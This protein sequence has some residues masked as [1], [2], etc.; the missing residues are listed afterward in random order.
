V[1]YGVTGTGHW[2]GSSSGIP[3]W[4]E[5]PVQPPAPPKPKRTTNKFGGPKGTKKDAQGRSP[6]QRR[7]AG[8]NTDSESVESKNSAVAAN[9]QR[10]IDKRA[11][12]AAIAQKRAKVEAKQARR[13]A[14]IEKK[15][16]KAEADAQALIDANNQKIAALNQQRVA[17]AKSGNVTA[18]RGIGKTIDSLL[19]QNAGYVAQGAD[20]KVGLARTLANNT[21]QKDTAADG[22]PLTPEQKRRRKRRTRNAKDDII[23]QST[24]PSLAAVVHGEKRPGDFG[25]AKNIDR[26]RADLEAYYAAH[27]EQYDTKILNKLSGYLAKHQK[28]VNDE[29]EEAVAEG[30]R[31]MAALKKSKPGSPAYNKVVNKIIKLKAKFDESNVAQQLDYLYGKDASSNIKGTKRK[32]PGG[33]IGRYVKS[34]DAMYDSAQQSQNN[35][36]FGP[37]LGGIIRGA[38]AKGRAAV[39]ISDAEKTAHM[40][41]DP[42]FPGGK[43]MQTT[44]ERLIEMYAERGDALTEEQALAQGQAELIDYRNRG[45][46][47]MNDPVM[48][49]IVPLLVENDINTNL[50]LTGDFDEVVL[51]K[52]IIAPGVSAAQDEFKADPSNYEPAGVALG[53]YNYDQYGRDSEGEYFIL[54]DGTIVRPGDRMPEGHE[55]PRWKHGPDQSKALW[56]R[57]DFF[58]LAHSD[59]LFAVPLSVQQEKDAALKLKKGLQD[60]EDQV[61]AEF[62]VQDPGFIGDLQSAHVVG[63][64][65]DFFGGIGGFWLGAADLLAPGDIGVGFSND[66]IQGE[67]V[68]SILTEKMWDPEAGEAGEEVL[69]FGPNQGWKQVEEMP[70]GVG[71]THNVL[72]FLFDTQTT[73]VGRTAADGSQEGVI[74][75]VYNV[76]FGNIEITS[77]Q[78]VEAI[79]REEE[80][81]EANLEGLKS[82]DFGLYGRLAGTN[83]AVQLGGAAGGINFAIEILTDPTNVFPFA[84]V[85]KGGLRAVK[86]GVKAGRNIDGSLA[87]LANVVDAMRG[88]GRIDPATVELANIRK[89]LDDVAPNASPDEATEAFVRAIHN[90]NQNLKGD[91]AINDLGKQLDHALG[92]SA[93]GYDAGQIR[94]FAAEQFEA[95]IKNRGWIIHS[96]ADA[97]ALQL[98]AAAA[99]VAFAAAN[100]A[101][102]IQRIGIRNQKIIDDLSRIGE[103]ARRKVSPVRAGQEAF[104]REALKLADEI[105]LNKLEAMA[106]ED[107]LSKSRKALLERARDLSRERAGIK[108][109]A[110]TKEGAKGRVILDESAFK[111]AK[112]VSKAEA[113]RV[114]KAEV[115]ALAVRNQKARAAR[116]AKRRAAEADAARVRKSQAPAEGIRAPRVKSAQQSLPAGYIDQANPAWAQKSGGPRFWDESLAAGRAGG[117][118]IEQN[119]SEALNFVESVVERF[120]KWT[121]SVPARK[122][123]TNR[124]VARVF[125]D[126]K[127]LNGSEGRAL[128]AAYIRNAPGF[129][130]N[131][132]L[133]RAGDTITDLDTG[134]IIKLADTDAPSFDDFTRMWAERGRKGAAS[135]YGPEIAGAYEDALALG[136]IGAESA[137][138]RTVQFTL[139]MQFNPNAGADEALRYLDDMA[140]FGEDA[141]VF[142]RGFFADEINAFHAQVGEAVTRLG[143]GAEDLFDASIG[144]LALRI[145]GPPQ[146]LAGRVVDVGPAVRKADDLLGAREVNVEAMVN[147]VITNPED[148]AN[149]QAL[150]HL[151]VIANLTGDQWDAAAKAARAFGKASHSSKTGKAARALREQMSKEMEAVGYKAGPRQKAPAVSLHGPEIVDDVV[152]Q[153]FILY[154]G[155][156]KGLQGA[157]DAKET[158]LGRGIYL[159]DETSAAGYAKR[160]ARPLAQGGDEG[161]VRQ[162]VAPAGRY[163]DSRT[164]PLPQPILDEWVTYLRTVMA[165]E[166][167]GWAVQARA[168]STLENFAEASKK[169]LSRDLV[170]GFDADFTKMLQKR[171]YVGLLAK[172]GGEGA[173]VGTH[174]SALVF[175]SKSV[176]QTES[177]FIPDAQRIASQQ[178]AAFLN[179]M[180]QSETQWLQA[181]LR[182]NT[183]RINNSKTVKQER[184]WLLQ[185]NDELR[186]AIDDIKIRK[187]GGTYKPPRATQEQAMNGAEN[188]REKVKGVIPPK[189]HAFF[190][191]TLEQAKVELAR[192]IR[193]SVKNSTVRGARNAELDEFM[194]WFPIAKYA[195]LND[196]VGRAIQKVQGKRESSLNLRRPPGDE[197]PDEIL[198]TLSDEH[199]LILKAKV[200]EL[201]AFAR[202]NNLQ[203]IPVEMYDRLRTLIQPQQSRYNRTQVL[204][205]AADGQSDEAYL[206]MRRV[207]TDQDAVD[208]IAWMLRE[209]PGMTVDEAQEILAASY[210]TSGRVKPVPKVITPSDADVLGKYFEHLTGSNIDDI[211]GVK[212]ALSAHGTKPNF[213]KKYRFSQHQERTGE[214]SPRAAA[215]VD[216]TRP[217]WSLDEEK[218]WFMDRYGEAPAWVTDEAITS[219]RAFKTRQSYNETM[220]RVGSYDER[221]R[222]LKSL[223]EDDPKSLEDI[224]HGNIQKGI[225]P[226]KDKARERLWNVQ[227][228]G[229]RVGRV[230][231]D[232]TVHMT[233]MPWLMNS[234]ELAELGMS[235]V[236]DAGA[237][238]FK[239][240]DVAA[241]KKAIADIVE[242]HADD[243]E[244]ALSVPDDSY[245]LVPSSAVHEYSYRMMLE[246]G[247]SQPWR[248]AYQWMDN[249]HFL[250]AWSAV[251]TGLITGNPAWMVSNFVD[252]PTKALYFAFTNPFS[253]QASKSSHEAIRSLDDLGISS[254]AYFDEIAERGIRTRLNPTTSYGKAD[255]LRGLWDLATL[256]PV[257]M[258]AVSE[259]E[260]WAKTKLARRIYTG[261]EEE[262]TP[263][264]RAMGLSD[265]NVKLALLK[266][267]KDNINRMFPIL[268]N[269]GFAQKLLNKILPFISYNA[270]NKILWITEVMDHPWMI[271]VLDQ[272]KGGL[273]EYNERNWRED[274]PGE[275]FMPEHLFNQIR[276]PGTDIHIDL[277][278]FTDFARGRFPLWEAQT[279]G[280]ILNNGVRP[281]PSQ[282]AF[283]E[284]AGWNLFGA[285]GRQRWE[286][287]LNEDGTWSGEVKR[288]TVPPGTPWGDSAFDLWKD[289]AWPASFIEAVN[290]AAQNDERGLADVVR[291]IGSLAS[292][293]EFA[294]P[295]RYFYANQQY[296]LL[297]D[298]DPELARDWL[299]D[300]EEGKFLKS[301]WDAQFTK[302]THTA[303]DPAI[304][305][306]LNLEGPMPN[307]MDPKVIRKG[308]YMDQSP[309]YRAMLGD[310]WNELS[311]AKEY[312]DE[313]YDLAKTDAER[314]RLQLLRR[315]WYSDFYHRN[316]HLWQY[317][318]MG[319]TE[320][321]YM[322]EV[323]KNQMED[324]VTRFYSVFDWDLKP[325]GEKAGAIWEKNRE[326]Y[327]KKNPALLKYFEEAKSQYDQN[328]DDVNAAWDQAFDNLEDMKHLR[329]EAWEIDDPR[330]AQALTELGDIFDNSFNWE[331]FGVD[332]DSK[333][334]VKMGKDLLGLSIK[335]VLREG[336]D[337]KDAWYGQRMQAVSEKAG[338]ERDRWF[339]IMDKNPDLKNIYFEKHPDKAV[340]WHRDREYAQFWGRFSRL[341]DK[342]KWDAAWDSWA[343][344]PQRVKDRYRQESPAKYRSFVQSYQYQNYMGRWMAYFD[345]G[346][347]AGAF[348]YFDSLPQWVKDKYFANHPGS[349]MN[350]GQGSAYVSNLNAVFDQIDKGNWDAAEKLWNAM[351]AW[352]RRRYYANNPSSTL[353][354]GKAKG[355]GIS[356]AKYK[357]YIRH[358]K[359]WVD[360]LRDGKDKEADKFFKSMPEWMQDFYLK[361]HPDK[362]LL[363]ETLKMQSLLQVYFGAN[364]ASQRAMLEN[365]PALARWLNANDTKAARINA[366]MF[367]YSRLPDDPW[368]K[369]VYREKY[370]EI[371][372]KEAKG[373]QTKKKIQDIL[374]DNPE[375]RP[376]WQKWLED[377]NYTLSEAEKHAL[378][379]PKQVEVDHEYQR[380]SSHA[381]MS[382]AEIG[383]DIDEIVKHEDTSTIRDARIS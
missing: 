129:P 362:A 145:D 299:N 350:R 288:V 231:P 300:S 165:D 336:G 343:E 168:A 272:A 258:K 265:E 116:L 260:M 1:P 44:E 146:N 136:R 202:E 221:Q 162:M 84:A 180:G 173:D 220:E 376:L 164:Q 259:P 51:E 194:S 73:A 42:A 143:P 315:T 240:D 276:I 223:V 87:S 56:D 200:D 229:D 249:N 82:G 181:Q 30:E 48:K 214:W 238:F 37:G 21:L 262:L 337:V 40:I 11:R 154:T 380:R 292:F 77:V 187:E 83:Q 15:V 171:G 371:F 134:E 127:A 4:V 294:E 128:Y 61:R 358:M 93:K 309:E 360:L 246:L 213:D 329:D 347:K 335:K 354:N 218:K 247:S 321:E 244:R 370:P 216:E 209:N 176:R 112:R 351:P 207:A 115:D 290:K 26:A 296:H 27:P 142:V 331:S 304:L 359:Q 193:V 208:N 196:R 183:G 102:T 346:D 282:V 99:E 211:E 89:F 58:D 71:W 104:E 302:P 133:N 144:R 74:T 325:E 284:S 289:L 279:V 298:S 101:A 72:D 78:S 192:S 201:A 378:K 155:G 199:P 79:E 275:R 274:H 319:M 323:A 348:A 64:I 341:A 2:E 151:L 215:D 158:T 235:S 255:A 228:Y 170:E 174:L 254:T 156:R 251:W 63:P 92:L 49:H 70:S 269:A 212:S 190:A 179:E 357:Q 372:S 123:M 149:T 9:T 110:V 333:S 273:I 47:W 241:M 305:T 204:I 67:H 147:R 120:G 45:L 291:I 100:N 117:R 17:A 94:A 96:Q 369:R 345:R 8:R 314:E 178:H 353:F 66:I 75:W 381:G 237:V 281:L 135:V 41:E 318:G 277:G 138:E 311:W 175:D 76:G 140:A 332:E 139:R 198:R 316:P 167:R 88:A 43:R 55:E 6:K 195:D 5:D 263:G 355:G 13:L 121:H 137:Y 242:K 105:P 159:T 18:I 270:K 328:R 160:R 54:N 12:A 59:D 373:E 23:E 295:S 124:G 252:N 25:F 322:E 368:L 374:D 122:A 98:D 334:G 34:Q 271:Y 69:K 80:M 222:L 267:T 50:D 330:A 234:D 301:M 109:G 106:V 306:M 293:G 297:Y 46:E 7:Q 65:V 287:V 166:S 131:G 19:S 125:K 85:S 230:D 60:I 339:G 303:V 177:S 326:E 10:K 327:L 108:A 253:R 243:F 266:A 261:L 191:R 150:A 172:E 349:K 285:F 33:L 53:I 20:A 375:L 366:I 340:S 14:K 278:M 62:R 157:G 81:R 189:V 206:A 103:Q 32:K 217:A 185:Q 132:R 152:A 338:D 97:I 118:T 86:A 184:A 95:V 364:K 39:L 312:W 232:G 107:G 148:L 352:M 119:G 114:R 163:L 256:R 91:S 320:G 264:L 313:Q 379:R 186:L 205:K 16:A 35:Q 286:K 36:M 356:D 113:A 307:P 225:K 245:K 188:V 22:E 236:D 317:I 257:S 219:G 130:P 308:W 203:E 227:R 280:S 52:N 31:L 361:A 57:V 224:A 382:A 153:D 283:L 310:G 3:Y 210:Y 268:E 126:P 161:E 182:R 344:A 90:M 29:N 233:D 24:I 377:I 68:S 111:G 342:G 365:N 367:A 169:P 250:A 226:V 141:K 324:E 197:L 28:S 248:K 239:A 38:R 383:E 363:K